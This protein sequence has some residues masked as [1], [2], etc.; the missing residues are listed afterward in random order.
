MIPLEADAVFVVRQVPETCAKPPEHPVMDEQPVQLVKETRTPLPADRP[1]RVDY[2]RAG[3]ASTFMEALS[4]WRTARKRRTNRAAEVASLP[5]GRDC[6]KIA[7]LDTHTSGAFYEA[8]RPGAGTG[9][10]NRVP[11]HA[12]AREPAEPRG[13][14]SMTRQCPVGRARLSGSRR[15]P[16]TSGSAASTGR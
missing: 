2:E 16:S 14:G 9:S 4:A 12:E 5:E 10:A 3:A 6:E 7:R 13:P 1:R 15:G 8:A 11:L